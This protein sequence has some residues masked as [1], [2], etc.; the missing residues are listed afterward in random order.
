MLEAIERHTTYEERLRAFVKEA[1]AADR[2]IDR[3]GAVYAADDVHAWLDR[4]ASRAGEPRPKP[5]RR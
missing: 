2:T 5:W 3:G 1:L 4:L